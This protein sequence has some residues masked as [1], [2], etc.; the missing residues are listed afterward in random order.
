[1]IFERQET[2]ALLDGDGA[3]ESPI[4]AR[5][6]AKLTGLRHRRRPR[7][8]RAEPGAAGGKG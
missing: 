8:H 2:A 4:G 3:S 1:M 7:G 5:I 6:L